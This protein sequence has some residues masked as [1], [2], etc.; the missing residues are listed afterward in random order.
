MTLGVFTTLAAASVRSRA[1]AIAVSGFSLTTPA[2]VASS[3]LFRF[4]DILTL[5]VD[6]GVLHLSSI[7]ST[8]PVIFGAL[9][10]D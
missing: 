5:D 4:P 3:P 2:A 1:A 8:K 9:A 6:A 10:F 7:S